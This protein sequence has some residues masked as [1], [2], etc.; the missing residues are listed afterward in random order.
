MSLPKDITR[1]DIQ[2]SLY[3]YYASANAPK[4]QPLLSDTNRC[5]N[6]NSSAPIL[7]FPQSVVHTVMKNMANRETTNRG[8]LVLHSTGSG[9]TL[10]ATSVMDAFWASKKEIVFVTSVEASNS[11]PP[12]NF[13]RLAKFFP[14]FQEKSIESIKK[15]FERRKVKFFTFATLAHYLMIANPL[16]SVNK[17]TEIETHK[18]FLNDAILIIDEVHN[19]FK[20]LPNQKLENDALRKFLMDFSN[21]N[22][23]NLKIVIL[24][25][26]P[27]DSPKD[28][29]SLL[30][31]VRDTKSNPI[32]IPDTN[33]YD[34]M[35]SFAQNIR[36]LVSYFDMSKDHSRFPRVIMEKPDKERMSSKQYIRYTEA[37]N[38]EPNTNIDADTLFKEKQFGKYYKHS[39]RYSNMLY[40]NEPNMA[41]AEFSAKLPALL[42]TLREYPN[43]KHY[44]YSSFYENRGYGGQGI[45]AIAK[46]LE[47]ELSFD[48]MTVS[49]AEKQKNGFD[50]EKRPRYV[51]AIST[52]LSE[53]REKLKSIVT[54]FNRP[55]NARGEYIQVFL[56]SQGY[57]EGI[58]LKGV[59]HIHIFE[60]LLTFSAEKQTIGRAA[61]FCSHSDLNRDVGEWTVR[62]HKYISEE[63]EDL[64]MFNLNYFMDRLQYFKGELAKKQEKYDVLK[65]HGKNYKE[66]CETL[67]TE[68]KAIKGMVRDLEKKYKEVEKMNLKNVKMIDAKIVKEARQRSSDMLLLVNVMRTSAI[69]Y[70][71]FRDYHEL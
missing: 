41:L 53:S 71:L 65:A 22:T 67:F 16:K 27:G 70:L 66:L 52:E 4:H 56:A 69:D 61:R 64:S 30:N 1:E 14:R 18:K 20:P 55:E 24:T 35:E 44:I 34:Q 5:N 51:V 9:K 10:T 12:S 57:N 43:E 8:L 68:I 58:D 6:S 31:M 17:N 59:R 40:D 15:E 19:I 62:V 21:P 32:K 2:R 13:H 3:D 37:Y 54:A 39:R 60:P 26:T 33:D 47:K 42:S 38:K 28:V 50:I 23:Q 29:V 46:T 11:N 63:P 45:I 7:S 49:M 25:A 36:G 48:K